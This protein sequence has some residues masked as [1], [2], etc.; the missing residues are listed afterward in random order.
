MDGDDDI[1]ALDAAV[2]RLRILLPIQPYIQT[3]PQDEPRYHHYSRESADQWLKKAPFERSEHP[4]LQYQTWFY[5]EHG[6]DTIHLRIQSQM[7]DKLAVPRPVKQE[8]PRSGLNTPNLGPKKK[9]SL[10]AYKDKK[11]HGVGVTSIVDGKTPV[12][13]SG[14][15]RKD[16]VHA[17]SEAGIVKA[18]DMAIESTRNENRELAGSVN[19]TKRKRTETDVV[20]A[21]DGSADGK[22]SS[23]GT[24]KR[25]RALPAV[26]QHHRSPRMGDRQEAV[27]TDETVNALPDRLS[28]L[29]LPL[30]G[31]LSPTLP[32]N[33][34][35]E[36]DRR[37][38]ERAHSHSSGESSKTSIERVDSKH[39]SIMSHGKN[40]AHA[41]DESEEDNMPL[42]QRPLDRRK[43]NEVEGQTA[44]LK[45]LS[46]ARERSLPQP[47]RGELIADSIAQKKAM[48]SSGAPRADRPRL[49]VRFKI[50]KRL[51][52]DY[53]RLLQF[54]PRPNLRRSPD[55]YQD[56]QST[57]DRGIILSVSKEQTRE[58]P[59]TSQSKQTISKTLPKSSLVI[60]NETS[61][62]S[63]SQP[64][65]QKSDDKKLKTPE[66]SP[67]HSSSSTQKAIFATPSSLSL[68][69]I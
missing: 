62:A 49:L 10:A 66:R 67:F 38:R 52:Q 6:S 20:S 27:T 5:H 24:S 28:P 36:L 53:R 57:E 44:D 25:A 29:S 23:P 59:P 69:H 16:T 61:P 18:R 21:T 7:E 13:S 32:Q 37:A 30:P 2:D 48:T 51:R 68:I 40:T 46:K 45:Q 33:V 9:I 47:E 8:A 31:R 58:K 63:H 42:K 15:S 12:Q 54:P 39:D 19:G 43:E 11:V 34:V 35:A 65:R 55:P 41:Q 22:V 26:T 3:I 4:D 17:H 60:K 64:A 1:K 56:G 14:E 50:P